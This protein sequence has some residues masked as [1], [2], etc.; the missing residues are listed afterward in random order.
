MKNRLL[1]F[2]ITCVSVFLL[3]GCSS[4]TPAQHEYRL[5]TDMQISKSAKTSCATQTL[6]VDRAFGARE[7]SSLKMYYVIGK[8]TQYAYANSR[9]AQSVNDAVTKE[10]TVYLREMALFKS[11]QNANSKTENDMRLEITIDDF[12]HYFDE[13]EKNSYVSVAI[14]CNLIDENTHKTV[15]SKTFHGNMKT[16]SDDAR[17]GVIALNKA[18]ERI[19]KECGLW[20]K[21]VCIDR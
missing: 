5:Q 21:G 9:W 12:M 14:T 4:P 17:G 19:V 2:C 11:V 6:K 13:N 8:Y 1:I 18:L 7:Y 15:A 3:S 20:L 10:I 16:D